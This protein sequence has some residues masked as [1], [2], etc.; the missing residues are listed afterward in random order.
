GEGRGRQRMAQNA[1]VEA[2]NRE[3]ELA[4][5][6]LQQRAEQLALTSKYKSEFLANMSHE[7]RTPLNSLLNLAEMLADNAQ[8]NLAPK[9]VEF[10]KT[11]YAAGSDLQTL[12]DDILDMAKIESGTMTLDLGELP[13][14]ELQEYVERTFMPV[15][16]NKGL[17]FGVDLAASL[18]PAIYCDAKRLQQVLRNLLSNAFKFTEQGKVG[19]RVE[20]ADKGWSTDHPVLSGADAVVAFAVSDTGIGIPAD[21][22][23]IIFEPFQQA[24]SGSSRRYW[25]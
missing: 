13:F 24:D 25:G 6:S 23:R 9:Q 7:L 15:A 11:I 12:I 20:L 19:L 2:K 3:I 4:K 17:D 22:L 21:K 18:P 1:E 16:Q 5:L 8:G 10:A 14:A